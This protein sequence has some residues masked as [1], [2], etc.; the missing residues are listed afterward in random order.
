MR[1]GGGH[2]G[3]WQFAK[4]R[5]RGLSGLKGEGPDRFQAQP[6]ELKVPRGH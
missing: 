6:K 5:F 3:V 4:R 2:E 1:C